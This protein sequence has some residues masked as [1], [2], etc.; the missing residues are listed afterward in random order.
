MFSFVFTK[1]R[2]TRKAVMDESTRLLY[3]Y[4]TKPLRKVWKRASYQRAGWN[5]S[6]TLILEDTPQN[7]VDNYGNALYI[8]TFDAMETRKADSAL[9]ILQAFLDRLRD[10]PDV[11]TAEKRNWERLCA[12]AASRRPAP[13]RHAKSAPSGIGMTSS[14]EQNDRHDNSTSLEDRLLQAQQQKK[15]STVSSSQYHHTQAAYLTQYQ[16]GNSS[17]L[18]ALSSTSAASSRTTTTATSG[19]SAYSL[20][21]S[22]SSSSVSSSYSVSSASSGAPYANPDS[23]LYKHHSIAAAGSKNSAKLSSSVDITTHV[24][25]A[26]QSVLGSS[27]ASSAAVSSLYTSA[28]FAH[29]W[30]WPGAKNLSN[31]SS[32]NSNSCSSTA[33]VMNAGSSASLSSQQHLQKKLPQFLPDEIPVRLVSTAQIPSNF[34]S[35]ASATDASSSSFNS[36]AS[37]NANATQK[38]AKPA[39]LKHSA[40]SEALMT[41]PSSL[42]S[43]TISLGP[44]RSESYH[45]SIQHP[46]IDETD[47]DSDLEDSYQRWGSRIQEEEEFSSS[48]ACQEDSDS[49]E[50]ES[51]DEDFD[52][53]EGEEDFHGDFTEQGDDDGEKEG[54]ENDEKSDRSDARFKQA[55]QASN[56]AHNM[57]LVVVNVYSS[58]SSTSKSSSSA[59][60]QSKSYESDELY[61]EPSGTRTRRD[62]EDEC[63]EE[64]EVD[65]RSSDRESQVTQTT[66]EGDEER[67]RE[68]FDSKPSDFFGKR[69]SRTDSIEYDNSDAEEQDIGDTDSEM[70]YDD[71]EELLMEENALRSSFSALPSLASVYAAEINARPLGNSTFS[72]RAAFEN[73]QASM[74]TNTSASNSNSNLNHPTNSTRGSFSHSISSVIANTNAALNAM[75]GVMSMRNEGSSEVS[76]LTAQLAALVL[77]TPPQNGGSNIT[78]SMASV[79][80]SSKKTPQRSN[81]ERFKKTAAFLSASSQHSAASRSSWSSTDSSRFLIEAPAAVAVGSGKLDALDDDILL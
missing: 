9:L 53:K 40:T 81:F 44:S 62:F 50:N 45:G 43:T 71:S 72:P 30:P 59:T 80:S 68:K 57:T 1:D 75:G 70:S 13:L 39:L 8:R 47:E 26:Q 22:S 28:P 7:C 3:E 10:V 77:Q 76:A 31:S 32:S 63:E 17:S 79:A 25:Y 54:D 55:S 73:A 65:N 27:M 24:H 52:S 67:R 34:S 49:L 56:E 18:Y 69:S 36:S 12:S 5:A 6:N 78:T 14:S 60:S 61:P 23:Y 58:K 42:R 38:M 29:N 16:L 21:T 4:H 19:H 64:F 66:S 11:R 15:Q 74:A 2:C 46:A 20:S 48:G 51:D 35:S 41:V 37:K 33:A